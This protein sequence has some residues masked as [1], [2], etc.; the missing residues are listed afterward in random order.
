MNAVGDRIRIF[1]A[2][3]HIPAC[4]M[5]IGGLG[6]MAGPACVVPRQSVKLYDLCRAGRWPEAMTLQRGLW[7][8]NRA[9][10][11]YNL[12]ACIKGA[13]QIQGYD[14]GD[15]VPPQAALNES[16]RAEIGQ[17]LAELAAL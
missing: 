16:G 14:V 7:R 8:I 15:P 4:V 5:L 6:W 13:L 1:S 12:A 9:F 3:A 11:K 2:S 10:A 17:L